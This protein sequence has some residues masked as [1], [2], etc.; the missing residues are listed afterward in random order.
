MDVIVEYTAQLKSAAGTGRD[1]LALPAG[2][3]LSAALRSAAERH[4]E[5]FRRQLL[6]ADGS[7]RGAL[8]VFHNDRQVRPGSDPE[9]SDGA[10]ITVMSPISGG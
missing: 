9:L 5:E 6:A 1:E 7:V 10:T 8:L 4:S 3:R 2:S